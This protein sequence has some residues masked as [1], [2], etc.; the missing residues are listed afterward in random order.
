MSKLKLFN[1]AINVFYRSTKY[2]N[3]IFIDLSHVDKTINS[4]NPPPTQHMK[5]GT[6]ALTQS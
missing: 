5:I 1:S 6:C 4:F 2:F 3:D